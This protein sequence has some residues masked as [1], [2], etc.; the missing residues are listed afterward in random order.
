MGIEPTRGRANDPSTALKAAGP[1]RRPDTPKPNH[2]IHFAASM[3]R[4]GLPALG[5]VRKSAA[6]GSGAILDVRRHAACPA[7]GYNLAENGPCRMRNGEGLAA[8]TPRTSQP[9][10]A[11]QILIVAFIGSVLLGSLVVFA[12]YE[13]VHPN[14][15]WSLLVWSPFAGVLLLLGAVA[16]VATGVAY[17]FQREPRV[18]VALCGSG[19]LFGVTFVSSARVAST[20][21]CEAFAALAERSAPLVTAIKTFE[22][23]KG[24]PPTSLDELVPAF[25]PHVPTT[26]LGAYPEYQYIVGEAERYDGNPWVLTVS[27]PSAVLDFDEYFY[28]PLQNY[29]ARHPAGALERIGDWAYLHE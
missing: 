7:P 28:Y 8:M 17:L 10:T 5:L 24:R 29:P 6:G 3:H 12:N 13:A 27:T 9:H 20:I 14:G 2:F 4:P 21:R 15:S 11:V 26:G 25:L 18:A 23:A 16:A 1:T 22:S 19:L